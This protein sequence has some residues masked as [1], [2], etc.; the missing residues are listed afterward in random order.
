MKTYR[1]RRNVMGTCIDGKNG[2][3]DGQATEKRRA[4]MGQTI[5]GIRREYT[6]FEGLK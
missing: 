4:V 6:H 2:H 1:D 5:K 3:F